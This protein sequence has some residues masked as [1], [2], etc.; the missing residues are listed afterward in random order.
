MKNAPIVHKDKDINVFKLSEAPEYTR[1]PFLEKKTHLVKF[2]TEM[3]TVAGYSETLQDAEGNDLLGRHIIA[4]KEIVDTEKFAKIYIDAVKTM[5]KLDNSGVRIFT[6][7]LENLPI[8][9]DVVVLSATSIM[10]YCGYKSKTSVIAGINNLVQNNIIA[11]TISKNLYYI[12]P[13]II[14][15]GNRLSLI[16]S[17]EKAEGILPKKQKA[18]TENKNFDNDINR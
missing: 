18:L 7:I 10:K 1:N 14:F 5:W 11:K 17:Y 15:N 16:N 6:Y 12:N 2:G 3:R 13:L 4:K 9:G 8:N